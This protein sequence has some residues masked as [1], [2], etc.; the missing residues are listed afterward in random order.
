MGSANFIYVIVLIHYAQHCQ[1]QGGYL[2]SIDSQAENDFLSTHILASGLLNKWVA[3]GL[4]EERQR[5][6]FSKDIFLVFFVCA[7]LVAF[8]F[9]PLPY[10]VNLR[11]HSPSPPPPPPRHPC[12]LCALQIGGDGWSR[13][14]YSGCC[15]TITLK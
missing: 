12:T 8:A 5:S 9:S 2:V 11:I 1:T 3:I 15:T 10:A 7:G 6:T 4:R 14:L 13:L